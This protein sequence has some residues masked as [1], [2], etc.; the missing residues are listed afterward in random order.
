M[1]KEIVAFFAKAS[2][3]LW[4]NL[5]LILFLVFANSYMQIMCI[6]TLWAF[7]V[8]SICFIAVI[9]Y[10]IVQ[11]EN[12]KLV[13]LVS[14]IN[15]VSFMLFVYCL[16][17]MEE[18][19]LYGLVLLLAF[20]G[21]LILIPHYFAI[22]LFY[23]YIVKPTENRSRKFFLIG[24]LFSFIL[25]IYASFLYSKSVSDIQQNEVNNYKNIN[26]CFMTE[27]ILGMHFI[28]HTEFCEYDGWRPPKHEPLLILGRWFHE[29]KDPLNVSLQG[30]IKIYKKV[31][32]E[33]KIKFDCSCAYLYKGSYH[34][35]KLWK[36]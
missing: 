36:N 28:Y 17:F 9:I 21:F 6:P 10:P 26:Q 5:I 24:V 18:L 32:P 13:K 3:K 19:S 30:R 34:N 16:I 27:K 12:I 1:L 11:K 8:L 35:D 4:R 2:N 7:L 15:G 33:N 14:F 29:N 23:N 20:I 22:Q 31:F 25:P